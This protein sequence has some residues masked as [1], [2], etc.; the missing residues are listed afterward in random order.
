MPE[1]QIVAAPEYDLVDSVVALDV[2][3]TLIIGSNIRR[4]AVYFSLMGTLNPAWIRP[5]H[6]AAVDFGIQVMFESKPTVFRWPDDG[7]LPS[8]EWHGIVS[9][10]PEDLYVLEILR[11]PARGRR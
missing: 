10:G 9:A 8:L 4:V 6:E 7:I 3:S 1:N 5:A 2:T 11:N